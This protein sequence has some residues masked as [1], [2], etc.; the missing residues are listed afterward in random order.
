MSKRIEHIIKNEVEMKWC[1]RCKQY[2]Y[3]NKFHTVN[4]YSW[5]D[6]FYICAACVNKKRHNN[7]RHNALSAWEGIC[8]RVKKDQRYINRKTKIKI[9]KNAFIDWYVENW[10]HQCRVDRIDNSLHYEIGNI[11]LI[12]QVEHNFKVRSDRLKRLKIVELEG[13]RYCYKCEEL[14]PYVKFYKRKSKV[15]LQ[16]TLGLSENCKDCEKA[17]SRQYY[18][19]AKDGTIRGLK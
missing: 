14:K 9:G 5:D 4:G 17:Y 2:L 10:F 13:I 7:P 6:L 3:L 11:Q 19:E 12:T 1:S 18:T 16:N 15:S 8:K